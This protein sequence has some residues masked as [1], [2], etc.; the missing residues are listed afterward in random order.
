MRDEYVKDCLQRK[1]WQPIKDLLLPTWEE[2]QYLEATQPSF[3]FVTRVD[4]KVQ[5]EPET[6]DAWRSTLGPLSEALLRLGETNRA[7]EIV[8]AYFAKHPWEGLPKKAQELA[9]RCGQPGLAA[10]WGALVPP[11]R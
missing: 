7:D 2:Q 8:R 9:L 4:G 3:A 11:P 5:E 1:D 6:G 10:Q